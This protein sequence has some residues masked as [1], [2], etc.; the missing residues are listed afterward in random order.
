MPLYSILSA[1][2]DSVSATNQ[3]KLIH[4]NTITKYFVF[5]T[6]VKYERKIETGEVLRICIGKKFVNILSN[7]VLL[8][9]NGRERWPHEIPKFV[10]TNN[11]WLFSISVCEV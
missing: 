5:L 8:S 4:D 2:C 7:R 9:K 3:L 1:L 10:S 11:F 6:S